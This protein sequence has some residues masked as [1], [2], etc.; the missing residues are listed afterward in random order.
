MNTRRNE[1]IGCN[2]VNGRGSRDE[3]GPG[4]RYNQLYNDEIETYS[5]WIAWLEPANQP[6]PRASSSFLSALYIYIYIL[7]RVPGYFAGTTSPFLRAWVKKM[8]NRSKSDHDISVAKRG[9][10]ES[11]ILL[12]TEKYFFTSLTIFSLPSKGSDSTLY[13]WIKFPWCEK[14]ILLDRST[15]RE[16]N[17]LSV[18]ACLFLTNKQTKKV[19]KKRKR[20]GEERGDRRNNGRNE[21]SEGKNAEQWRRQRI[22][23]KKGMILWVG[24]IY[25]SL[26]LPNT[27]ALVHCTSSSGNAVRRMG[28]GL[29]SPR[30]RVARSHAVTR[31]SSNGM[32]AL[33]I[34][35]CALGGARATRPTP[36]PIRSERKVATQWIFSVWRNG[37]GD[38]RY[39]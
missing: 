24:E 4:G 35:S 23:R 9:C 21:K 29:F 26:F 7:S 6:F 20:K 12:S 25:L 15:E 10:C 22:K 34:N 8:G 3:H 18:D 1:T 36:Y 16:R 17:I 19:E 37:R 28:I 27:I 32:A 2:L 33:L 38:S 13:R 39:L 31:R 14:W 30:T 5:E 11:S